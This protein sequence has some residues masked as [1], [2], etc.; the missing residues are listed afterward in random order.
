MRQQGDPHPVDSALF[1][2]KWEKLL[3]QENPFYNS[4]LNKHGT[5]FQPKF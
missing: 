2:Q 4:N 1:R 5:M 3:K